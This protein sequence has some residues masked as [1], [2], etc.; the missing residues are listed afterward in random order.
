MISTKIFTKLK[1]T[2]VCCNRL[3]SIRNFCDKSNEKSKS[4]VED[5]TKKLG[6]FSKKYQLFQEK[7]SEVVLDIYEE[8]LKYT[9]ML[10][11]EEIEEEDPFQGLN[12]E[13]KFC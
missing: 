7:D 2:H 6:D 9:N 5:E 4:P 1:P 8:R 11:N 3:L 12:L 10:E 13:R